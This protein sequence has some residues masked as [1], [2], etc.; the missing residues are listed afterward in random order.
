M[1]SD[2]NALN[3]ENRHTVTPSGWTHEQDNTKVRRKGD[4]TETTL[5]RE[6]GFNDYRSISGYDFAP[7]YD[8]WEKTSRYWALVRAAWLNHFGEKEQIIINTGV[9][10]MPV[11][12]ATF[13][14]AEA[15][16]SGEPIPNFEAIYTL[17]S[18][19]VN[20]SPAKTYATKK[21]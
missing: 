2:Y 8:Y 3:V 1:R 7:A 19:W 13:A 17:L 6:F 16:E 10:G 5:V 14:Q 21:D 11:I 20:I 9:D 15:I 4:A 12:E 18:Q